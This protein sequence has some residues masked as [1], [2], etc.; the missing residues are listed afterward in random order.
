[1][2]EMSP[3]NEPAYAAY[4][5]FDWG[6]REHAWAL[7]TEGRG[8][9]ERGKLKHSPEAIHAWAV[10]LG[11]RFG[12]QPI[13]VG[14]EQSRGALIYALQAY[15]HL[16]LYPIHPA[17]SSRY[18]AAMFPSGSKDDPQDAELLLDLLVYHRDHLRNW[19]P[20]TEETRKLQVFTEKRRQL[21]DQLTAQTNR[22]QDLL[23]LYFP[24]VLEW[25]DELHSPLGVA[26]LQRWPTLQQLQQ[27]D[28]EVVR[29]FFYEHGSR[30]RARIEQRL[31]AIPQARPAIE[32][33]AVIDPCVLMVQALLPVVTALREG[34][35]GFQKAIDQIFHQ[36]PDAA[37][38][39][40]FPG[41]GCVMAP[42]LL[43]AFGSQRT[44]WDRV[45]DFQNY[46]GIPPITIR[47]GKS[48]GVHFRWACPKFLRQT[49]HE[50][51]GLSIQQSEWARAFYHHQRQHKRLD[52][53]A[54]VRSLAYK[55]QRILYRCWQNR[56]LYQESVY[57]QQLNRKHPIP[58]ISAASPDP[59]QPRQSAQ[60]IRTNHVHF[61]F[62]NVAG[63]CKLAG[64]TS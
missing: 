14:L 32:D 10:E 42:R 1:M 47:S 53:H 2:S 59:V 29:R 28:P 20:D 57:Q 45:Q 21:V 39:A 11:T 9:R 12:G 36:H 3:S 19:R 37:L 35:V 60:P 5:A 30:S 62:I 51:A 61:Q 17:T 13:A 54:A 55:W 16:V 7:E 38:F 31:T 34:I 15:G 23:K 49:F 4:V 24:Q 8:K 52:H 33:R 44:R 40:S 43:A 58:A 27:E 41:A 50:Y 46:S 18:R 63:F 56:T 25:L 26:F 48:K 22:I 6:D 64:Q